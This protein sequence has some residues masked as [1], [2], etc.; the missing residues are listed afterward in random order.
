MVESY[1]L[2]AK[3][4]SLHINCGGEEVYINNSKIYAADTEGAGASSYYNGGNWAFSST[5]HF[6]DV[7][8]GPSVY[9]I[10]NTS[11]LDNISTYEKQLYRSARTSGISLTYYGL[12]LMNGKYSI[13]LHFAE[14]VFTRNSP[15]KRVFDVYVQGDLKLKDF[16]IVR[17][18]GGTGRPVIKS[19]IIDVRNNTLKIQLY[20]AGKGTTR[21]PYSGS[22]GPCISAISVDPNFEPPNFGKKIDVGMI[23]ATVTGGV[24][25]VFLV[26][27]ILWKM[28]FLTLKKTAHREL[29]SVDL[30]TGIFTLRQIKAAT[31]N[32]HPSREIGQGGFGSVYKGLLSDG[33]IIAVKQLSL[34]SSQG[35]NEFMRELGLLS[36]LRH[37]NLVK[38]YGSCVEGKQFSLIYEYM[39]NKCLSSALLGTHT[40]LSTI[41]VQTD[42]SK[43][44]GVKMVLSSTGL[45]VP[46]SFFF[47][48][49]NM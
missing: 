49:C 6:L 15:G 34:A 16:E 27:V 1:S 24:F 41:H 20:W 11:N 37:Q 7:E 4:Y 12:C 48:L 44:S 14:I 32:F 21:I 25:M 40:V 22:Y 18:A 43:E 35:P 28:G 45:K 23:V 8:N 17:E 38:L 30:Q 39:E 36:A 10:S 29:T 5:G 46:A 26:I 9:N 31:E 47:G 19:Y 42:G 2:S 33:T 3:I 13:R